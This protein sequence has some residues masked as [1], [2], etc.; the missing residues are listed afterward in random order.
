MFDKII[1]NL[2]LLIVFGV[3]IIG[4]YI[5]I[6]ANYELDKMYFNDLEV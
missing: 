2:V 4:T 6:T 1:E 3:L 5:M